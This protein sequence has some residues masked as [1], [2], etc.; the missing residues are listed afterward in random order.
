[1][2]TTITPTRKKPRAFFTPA[3]REIIKALKQAVC[4]I[5]EISE[6]DFMTLD[7]H[8][9]AY[10]RFYCFWILAKK[11]SM[12]ETAIAEVFSKARATVQYGVEQ[13]E[14]QRNVYREMAGELRVIADTANG[15][16]KKFEW[17]IQ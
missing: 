9:V 4:S 10:L 17:C 7:N 5:Y 8:T 14:S 11:A 16:P 2:T 1:M 3:Q 6:A 13:I 15:Y 12:K